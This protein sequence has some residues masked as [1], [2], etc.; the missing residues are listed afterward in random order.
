MSTSLPR[1]TS[2]GCFKVKLDRGT[3]EYRLAED[4]KERQFRSTGRVY[5]R[6]REQD[7]YYEAMATRNEAAVARWEAL[8]S[9]QA[10]Q[11]SEE[12]ERQ[13]AEHADSRLTLERREEDLRLDVWEEEMLEITVMGQEHRLLLQK[14]DVDSIWERVQVEKKYRQREE[15]S[16]AAAVLGHRRAREALE[17][18]ELLSRG[19]VLRDEAA[20]WQV[21]TKNSAG[22]AEAAAAAA[23]KREAEEARLHEELSRRLRE[24]A[25]LA[26]VREAEQQLEAVERRLRRCS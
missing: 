14:H 26:A 5:Q 6:Q 9:A 11:D 19:A 13:L 12:R 22:Q 16:E 3:D 7:L 15:D 1:R 17:K 25:S 23:T 10:A 2:Q 24:E 4:L 21:A 20:G 8:R 18:T